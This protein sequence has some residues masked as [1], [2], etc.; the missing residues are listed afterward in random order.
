MLFLYFESPLSCHDRLPILKQA[1]KTLQGYHIL[2]IFTRTQCIWIYFPMNR[3][4][5]EKA[6]KRWPFLL[7]FA[8]NKYLTEYVIKDNQ[9]DTD[10]DFGN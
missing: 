6:I 2:D 4:A 7:R 3:K 1:K 10:K 8:K 5:K 9:Y